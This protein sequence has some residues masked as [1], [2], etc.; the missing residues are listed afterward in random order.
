ML[1][2]K[3]RDACLAQWMVIGERCAKISDSLKTAHP[4]VPWALIV[5]FKNRGSHSY[6]TRHYEESMLWDTVANDTPAI[7]EMYV[8]ILGDRRQP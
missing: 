1:D 6:G 3:T 8:A 5:G 7:R 4:E 2:G